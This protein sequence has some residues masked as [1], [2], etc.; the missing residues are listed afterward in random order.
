MKNDQIADALD[1]CFVSPNVEDSNGE[2]ANLVDVVN[3]LAF[4]TGQVAEAICPRGA[5][6]GKDAEGGH[7]GSLTEAVMGMTAGLCKI[8]EAIDGLADAVRETKERTNGR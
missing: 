4:R 3:R 1:R 7:V 5:A 2:A 6:S 8:A